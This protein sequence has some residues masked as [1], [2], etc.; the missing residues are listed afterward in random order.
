MNENVA[1]SLKGMRRYGPSV[2][3]SLLLHMGKREEARAATALVLIAIMREPCFTTSIL[4][5]LMTL[6]FMTTATH[7]NTNAITASSAAPAQVKAMLSGSNSLQCSPVETIVLSA[8]SFE[9]TA[10]G[11]LFEH[12][13]S[14]LV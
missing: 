7:V 3:L 11:R 2:H 13:F 8:R 14:C 12:V 5:Q 4:Q 6:P 10:A 9:P 1:A